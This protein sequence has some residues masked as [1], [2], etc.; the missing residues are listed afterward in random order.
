M[1][2]FFL[3]EEK[4]LCFADERYIFSNGLKYFCF[5]LANKRKIFLRF[6]VL[7]MLS[8]NSLLSKKDAVEKMIY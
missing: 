7:V 2:V 5:F 1:W 3:T 6:V 4:N 8:F